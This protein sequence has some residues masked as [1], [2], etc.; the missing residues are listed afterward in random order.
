VI[1]GMGGDE[2]CHMTQD[3]ALSSIID[4][5]PDAVG[6]KRRLSGKPFTILLTCKSYYGQP[7]V[8]S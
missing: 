1:K 8:I 7:A 5:Q 2:E 3:K 6:W 4:F